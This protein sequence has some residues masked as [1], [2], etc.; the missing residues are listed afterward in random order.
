MESARQSS[1][2]VITGELICQ[3]IDREFEQGLLMFKE[4]AQ[5]PSKSLDFETKSMI[6]T[7]LLGIVSEG[8]TLQTNH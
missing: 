3:T 2:P 1:Q 4:L 6:F 7:K 8:P 5:S